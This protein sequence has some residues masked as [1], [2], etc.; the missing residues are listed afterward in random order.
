VQESGRQQQLRKQ[1]SRVFQRMP[2]DLQSCILSSPSRAALMH[3][4]TRATRV[5]APP[6]LTCMWIHILLNFHAA[7]R[8]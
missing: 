8:H 7:L 2:R 4:P 1:L 6:L 5:H 3:H